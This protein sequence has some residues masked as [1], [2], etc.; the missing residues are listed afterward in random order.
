MFKCVIDHYHYCYK[1]HGFNI[2]PNACNT[3]SSFFNI[4][5]EG[6][7]TSIKGNRIKFEMPIV[8]KPIATINFIRSFKFL[9]MFSF[10]CVVLIPP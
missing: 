5:A 1:H 7:I 3:G 9:N 10:S 2:F 8:T 4:C 6:N